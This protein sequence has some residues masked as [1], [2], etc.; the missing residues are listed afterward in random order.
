MTLWSR[1]IGAWAI[2]AVLV[3]CAGSGRPDP[4][5][6]QA[7]EAK[8]SGKRVW[9]EDIGKVTFP[10]AVSVNGGVFTVADDSGLVLALQADTGKE[11]W[12]AEVG[13][14][15]SAGVGSDGR[16]TSVVTRDNQLVTLQAGK[17][18][19]RKPLPS[20]VVTAPLVAGERV[21]VVA[22]D[23][24]VHAFDAL[25]GRKLW[26]YQRPSDAL[27][28]ASASVLM[29][30][31]DTLVVGQG[32]KLVGLDPLV[33]T[34]RWEAT[35]ASPRGTN[36]V[37]RLADVVG[38]AARVRDVFCARAYQAAVACVNAER[39]STVWTRNA[40]GIVGVGADDQMV[41]GVDA[42][43]R[44][45]AWKTSDGTPAWTIEGLLYRSLSA[46][47]VLGKAVVVGD[48]KGMVHWF[49]RDTGEAV[50]RLPTD[51]SAIRSTPAASGLT[52]LVVTTDGGLYAF[53]PE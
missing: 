44:V 34:P 51:G 1:R 4:T 16:F 22:V 24:S 29:P 3:G 50:L 38:P 36:E 52:L 35:L 6:L 8:V 21:F 17:V 53:R 12:R 41:V 25:D 27:N 48:V 39:G 40:G 19:W 11:V 13:A 47:V 28:L 43:D 45:N 23:R 30:F 31:R 14:K 9:R 32:A 18:S 37:E 2:C 20:R 5:P 33:G 49:A 42:S 26:T 7:L 15:L 10:L 46:P